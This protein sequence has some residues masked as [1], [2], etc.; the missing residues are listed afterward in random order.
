MK[1]SNG[2]LGSISDVPII[3]TRVI[4]NPPGWML[5]QMPVSSGYR[6]VIYVHPDFLEEFKK[7]VQVQNGKQGQEK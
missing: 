3:T 6:A 7:Q 1:E 5:D 4:P 2:F